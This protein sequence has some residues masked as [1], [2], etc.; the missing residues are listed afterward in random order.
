MAFFSY[1][2]SKT[3]KYTS[4]V[5]WSLFPKLGMEEFEHQVSVSGF[6][7]FVCLPDDVVFIRDK[8]CL[9]PRDNTL[10]EMRLF[11]GQNDGGGQS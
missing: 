6:A 11:G 10:S 2:G 3:K 9:S 1:Y 4:R 8:V 5:R 7:V